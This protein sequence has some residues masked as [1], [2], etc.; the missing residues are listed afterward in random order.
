M[1]TMLGISINSTCASSPKKA[2][3]TQEESS[4]YSDN[5]CGC[6]QIMGLASWSKT[7]CCNSEQGVC[8]QMSSS[9]CGEVT[10]FR[11]GVL[12]TLF[13]VSPAH[14]VIFK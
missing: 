3:A 8:E 14:K 10:P 7:P 1:N 13:P 12:K 9:F 4:S 5:G 11:P 6:S 2:A